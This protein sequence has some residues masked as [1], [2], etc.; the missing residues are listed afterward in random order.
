MDCQITGCIRK[1]RTDNPQVI[2]LEDLEGNR[3]TF[4]VCPQHK[5]MMFNLT[6]DRFGVRWYGTAKLV[7]TTDED[8]AEKPVEESQELEEDPNEDLTEEQLEELT[9]PQGV[10]E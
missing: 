2:T 5:L 1:T 10:E 6:P 4:K 8:L 9:A 3:N 7:R